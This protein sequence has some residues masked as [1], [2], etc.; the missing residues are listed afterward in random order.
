MVLFLQMYNISLRLT[1]QWTILQVSSSWKQHGSQ[2]YW[3]KKHWISNTNLP[4]NLSL[5]FNHFN[6]LYDET[7]LQKQL[8]RYHTK[9]WNTCRSIENMLST[10]TKNNFFKN[11]LNDLKTHGKK[12]KTWSL[13]LNLLHL[14]QPN[15]PK[16]MNQ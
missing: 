3:W 15:F 5:L 10:L 16:I 2:D 8:E 14:Y 6:S 11:N 13:W 9:I 7:N 1:K 4:Q 12:S